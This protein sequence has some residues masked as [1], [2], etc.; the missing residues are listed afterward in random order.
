MTAKSTA[1]TTRSLTALLEVAMDL[2]A[3]LS[4]EARNQRLVEAVRKVF[5]C[6]AA[7]LLRLEGRELVPVA[8]TG[9]LPEAMRRRFDPAQEPRLD[10]ILRSHY[11][12]RFPVDDPRPDPF[13]GLLEGSS[14][15][16]APVHDCMGCSLRV[17]TELVGALTVDAM[18]LGAFDPVEDTELALFAALAAAAL[19]RMNQHL[20]SH[21][22]LCE[23]LNHVRVAQANAAVACG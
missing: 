11:P 22:H 14:S 20:R 1:K 10:A 16:K 5:P 8:T 17:G 13:D 18:R 23:Q 19:R 9:L 21:R 15:P 3:G 12:V 7:A 6:D 4:T 2:T